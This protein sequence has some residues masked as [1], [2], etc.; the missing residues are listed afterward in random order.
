MFLKYGLDLQPDMEAA[1][2]D[3][4][5]PMVQHN[6]GIGFVPAGFAEKALADNEVFFLHL[7]EPIPIRY[8]C[9]IKDEKR[10]L[11]VTAQELEK[12][13]CSSV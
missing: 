7:V 6:L 3:Q 4:I 5:L 1:T 12:R 2:T 9:L 8:I 11:S 10:S 13:L